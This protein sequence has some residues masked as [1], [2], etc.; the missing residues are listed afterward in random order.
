MGGGTCSFDGC[1][2]VIYHLG[3]GLCRGHRDQ[4]LRGVEMYPLRQRKSDTC[5]MDGCDAQYYAK[6]FCYFH[7]HDVRRHPC[8]DC[9]DRVLGESRR[10]RP[11]A[12][13]Y[14]RNGDSTANGYVRL[15]GHRDHPNANARGSILEHTFVMSKI[16]GRPLARGENVHHKNGNRSDNRPENLELWSTYQP[17]GQRVEDKAKWAKEILARYEPSALADHLRSDAS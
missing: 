7:Y 17:P 4:M 2:R 8:I 6:D 10:C 14:S 13:A 15:W 5:A 12:R 3:L 9:G 16:L 11:C 1:D